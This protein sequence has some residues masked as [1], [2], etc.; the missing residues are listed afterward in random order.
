V[1][2]VLGI[3]IILI[4]VVMSIELHSVITLEHKLSRLKDDYDQASRLSSKSSL[5]EQQLAEL[6]KREAVLKNKIPRNGKDPLRLSNA[7]SSLAINLGFS[8]ISFEVIPSDNSKGV[9]NSPSATRKR[10][11][12][13]VSSSHPSISRINLQMKAECDYLQL[14]QFLD[15][16]K[17]L[18]RLVVVK[19]IEII[20]KKTLLPRQEI[21]LKLEAYGS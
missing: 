9:I 6:N 15:R 10:I 4:G 21:V 16:I 18:S 20:R 1:N 12:K 5:L 17:K 8:H 19:E 2:K 3:V 14:L 11:K 13:A 7:I